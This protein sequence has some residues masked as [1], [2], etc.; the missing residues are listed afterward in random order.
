MRLIATSLIWRVVHLMAFAGSGRVCPPD[1]NGKCCDKI[2]LV[3]LVLLFFITIF[4]NFTFMV[5][6]F[7]RFKNGSYSTTIHS[8][9]IIQCYNFFCLKYSCSKFDTH[10]TMVSLLIRYKMTL[11]F[12][13]LNFN[14]PPYVY[15][16]FIYIS[17]SVSG[18]VLFYKHT[19][20]QITNGT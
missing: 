4:T 6:T 5:D 20:L 2:F 9:L 16:L 19:S 10:L 12:R 14:L 7:Y 1:S 17:I 18:K 8:H 13:V 15:M 3:P 11:P